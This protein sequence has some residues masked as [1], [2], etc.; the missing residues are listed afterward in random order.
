M[1]T[2]IKTDYLHNVRRTL[3]RGLTLTQL[4]KDYEYADFFQ[5][6]LDELERGGIKNLKQGIQ[7]DSDEMVYNIWTS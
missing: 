5:H 7:E 1:D 3:E 2:A 4:R 6:A